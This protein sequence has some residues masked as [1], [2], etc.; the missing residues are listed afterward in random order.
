MSTLAPPFDLVPQL[1]RGAAVTLQI[2]VMAAALAFILSFVL[3]AARMTRRHPVRAAATAYVE[4]FRGTSALVQLFYLFY[5]LPVFG[6]RLSATVTA[7]VGLGLNLGAYGSEVVRA[8][9]LS[10]GKG[11]HE[12]A[13]ALGLS[14]RQAMRLVILPQAFALIWPSF[15]NLLVELLKTSSLVSLITLTD[16]TFAGV[17]M[18]TTTGR[19]SEVW[20]LVLVIYFVMAYP[21]SRLALAAEQRATAYRRGQVARR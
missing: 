10:I 20:G 6:L 17:Q 14:R 19:A 1:L 18:V 2:T 4:V 12:A 9:I 8:A 11:Q 16:L 5:I 13:L 7:V 3:A 21:L 15:G